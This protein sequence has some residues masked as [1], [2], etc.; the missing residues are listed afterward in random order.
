MPRI[1]QL[2]ARRGLSGSDKAPISTI[3]SRR[4]IEPSRAGPADARVQVYRIRSR[5]LG[6]RRD[7]VHDAK[8]T[9]QVCPKSA[10]IPRRSVRAPRRISSNMLLRHL[11]VLRHNLQQ[12]PLHICAARVRKA[13]RTSVAFRVNSD[14]GRYRMPAT[15]RVSCSKAITSLA[16]ASA[17]G[18]MPAGN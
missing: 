18:A 17:V 7:G 14:S 6:W 3:G 11:S 16:S 9:G 10:I 8:G 15:G 5:D 2:P 4:I 13:P 1:A 12:N